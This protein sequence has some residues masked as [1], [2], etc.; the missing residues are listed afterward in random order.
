MYRH[1]TFSTGILVMIEDLLKYE[2][3][4]FI[5]ISFIRAI[6]DLLRFQG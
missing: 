5:S 3:S 4:E 6:L 2:Y 1:F